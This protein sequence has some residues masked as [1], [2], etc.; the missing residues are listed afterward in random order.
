HDLSATPSRLAGAPPPRAAEPAP[1]S[2]GRQLLAQHRT[3][4]R[5]IGRDHEEARVTALEELVVVAT[6]VDDHVREEPPVLVSL[7]GVELQRDALAREPRLRVVAG[8]M[9]EALHRL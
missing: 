2:P 7:F 8:D 6:P 1:V 5:S 3:R 9:P 4:V